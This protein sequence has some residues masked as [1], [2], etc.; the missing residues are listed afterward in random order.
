[1]L[2]SAILLA[3]ASPPMVRQEEFPAPD[4]KSGQ[5]SI[6]QGCTQD[7]TWCVTLKENS[8]DEHISHSITV[9]QSSGQTAQ[10]VIDY[11]DLSAANGAGLWTKP[12]VYRTA[13]GRSGLLFGIV[14]TQLESY[15]GGGAYAETLQWLRAETDASGHL[16]ITPM[17]D[18]VPFGGYAMIRACFSELDMKLRRGIC[19]DEYT[20]DVTLTL[21]PALV[22]DLPAF[23]YKSKA[24]V[25]PGFA[26]RATD[27][28]DPARLRALKA[29]DFKTR[30]D[31]RCTFTQPLQADA[32]RA[33]Y[34]LDVPDCSD[35][36]PGEQ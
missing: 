31:M 25:T 2:I 9:R 17:D 3:S 29:A 16:A 23:L 1:M 19:H 10:T 11:A 20:L 26:S 14:T 18:P 4:A 36:G 12:V 30:T 15:S 6:M 33:R 22:H 34:R 7:R 13:N 5:T 27:N 32:R 24:T 35:Y 21:K 28:S 8:D